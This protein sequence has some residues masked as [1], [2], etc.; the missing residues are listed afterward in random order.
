M[1]L[2]LYPLRFSGERGLMVWHWSDLHPLS[3][4]TR[5][6]ETLSLLP[7][8]ILLKF[9]KGAL[10]NVLLRARNE[11][12]VIVRAGHPIPRPYAKRRGPET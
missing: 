2:S 6:R 4:P 11:C 10:I 7:E 5:E 1:G 3:L 9:R 8:K 12:E